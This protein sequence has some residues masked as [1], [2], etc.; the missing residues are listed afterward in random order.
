MEVPTKC[1]ILVIGAGP[2]GLYALSKLKSQFPNK[3]IIGIDKGDICNNYYDYPNIEFHSTFDEI[4]FEDYDYNKI[5][6]NARIDTLDVLNYCLKYKNNKNLE[7]YE[8]LEMIDVQKNKNNTYDVKV[9]NSSRIIS[10]TSKYILLCTGIYSCPVYIGIQGE[11]TNPNISHYIFEMDEIN[12]NIVVVGNGNSAADCIIGLLPANKIH[13]I[14]KNDTEFNP[15]LSEFMK[16]KLKKVLEKYK[17]NIT[18]YYNSIVIDNFDNKL[19]F[20]NK[21][22]EYLIE[23]DKCYLLT[24][25]RINTKFFSKMGFSFI[26]NCFNYSSIT[27]ETNLKNIYVF[28]HLSCQWCGKTNTVEEKLLKD[29]SLKNITKIM[30]S[31]QIKNKDY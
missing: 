7:I 16:N 22:N 26:K 18:I 11:K 21:N 10:I 15:K 8:N 24:G 14:I 2:N 31:I 19:Y 17:D 25:Y 9:S 30:D 29:N 3:K 4:C 23:Y 1:F 28:G 6:K 13:W 27:M 20:K 5:D 12:Q